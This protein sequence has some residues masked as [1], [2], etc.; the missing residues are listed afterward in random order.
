MFELLSTAIVQASACHPGC[1]HDI[2]PVLTEKLGDL[3]VSKAARELC[4]ALTDVLGLN[5][6]ALR[7]CQAAKTHRSPKVGVLAQVPT[8]RNNRVATPSQY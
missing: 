6:V 3:K 4:Q 5:F 1:A 7:L 8:V 2:L